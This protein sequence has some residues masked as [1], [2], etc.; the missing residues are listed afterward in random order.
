MLPFQMLSLLVAQIAQNF[1][2]AE[3]VSQS[4]F[5]LMENQLLE[6]VTDAFVICYLY[7]AEISI[8]YKNAVHT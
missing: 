7:F 3:F 8:I 1:N 5:F 6:T 4:F 2:S